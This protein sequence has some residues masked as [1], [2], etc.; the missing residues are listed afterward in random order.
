MN[1]G[2]YGYSLPPNALTRVAPPEWKSYKLITATTSA[3]VVPQNVFQMGVA[4]WGG[5]ANGVAG[6]SGGGGGG[7]VH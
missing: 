4:V 1:K 6:I 5:G 7:R 3:E 2:N